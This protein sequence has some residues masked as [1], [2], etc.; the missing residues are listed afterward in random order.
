M[1]VKGELIVEGAKAFCSSSQANKSKATAVTVH[2]KSQT[3]KLGKNKY[4]AQDKPIATHL[5][6]KAENF[7]N[8]QAFVMCQDPKN[9]ST[10]YSPCA[11]MCKI[12]YKDFYENVEFNKSMKILIDKSTGTCP[13]YGVPGTIEFAKSGQTKGAS[14]IDVKEADPFAIANVSPQWESVLNSKEAS[15]VS[16]ISMLSPLAVKPNAE[17]KPEVYYFIKAAKNPLSFGLEMDTYLSLKATYKGDPQKIVWGLYKGEGIKDKVK[18]F[19]GIGANFN[20][21]LNSI[22]E[23]LEQGK[24]RI[25]AYVTKAN[26]SK[27]AFI[28][29]YVKDQIEAISAQGKTLV[30]NVPIPITLQYKIDSFSETTKILNQKMMGF[31]DTSPIAMWRIKQGETVLYNSLNGITSSFVNVIKGNPTV[32]TFKNIGEY[33]VEA[34]TD[35]NIEKPFSVSFK[36]LEQYGI[37]SVV[38]TSNI[39]LRYTDT[40]KVAVGKFN[41]EFAPTKNAQ[42]YL[43]KDGV[44]LKTFSQ[45]ATSKATSINRKIDQMLYNDAQGGSNYF[46]KYKLEAYATGVGAGKTP[47]FSGSDTFAFEV[48]QNQADKITLPLSI[49]KG[50]KVK[51]TATP[52]ISPMVGDEKLEIE[53]PD[54]V[55]NNNDGT[56]TFTEDGEFEIAVFMTGEYTIS[57]KVELKVKVTSPEVKNALWSYGTGYKRTETGYK[58]ETHGF[59]HI[60]GLENQTLP[61]KIWVKGE[62]E[63]IYSDASKKHLLEEKTVKLDDK[64]KGSFMI[65]TNDDY[66]KKIELAIPPTATNPNPTCRLVFTIELPTDASGGISLPDNMEI[67]HG[68]KVVGTKVIEILETNEELTL[69]NEKK[70]KSIV[71]STEDGKD[72]QRTISHYNRTHKIWVHT[73]NM[74]DDVL[75]IDVLKEVPRDAMVAVDNIVFTHESKQTYK[76]EKVGADGLLEV[77]FTVK[78]EWA[79]P[80]QNVDFYIAQVS[81]K[82]KDPNDDKKEI[83]TI[84]KTQITENSAVP[85]TIAHDKEMEKMG[86]KAQ[87]QD[88]SPFTVD[89]MVELRKKFMFY[90]MG[91]LKVSQLVSVEAISNDKSPVFVEIGEVNRQNAVCACKQNNFYWSARIS[92]EERKKVLEVCASLWG[93]AKKVE[94]ASE[95]M[96]IIHLETGKHTFKPSADNG[97]GYSGLIQFNDASAKALGTTREKLKAMTFIEQMDFVRDYFSKN[98]NALASMTDMYLLV[99]KPNA[100]GKGNEPSFVLFD[101]SISVPDGN[102]SGTS[103]QQ[104]LINVTQEPWVT[105]YGYA[106]NPPF[107]KGD[108]HTKRKKWVYTR[109]QY[110]QR[111]GFENGNTTVGEVTNELMLNH[112]DKGKPEKFAGS[113]K[114]A[115]NLDLKGRAPW[116]EIAVNEGKQY[117]GKKQS[118]IQDRVTQYHKEG[119]SYDVGTDAWCSSFACWCLENSTPKFVSPHSAGSRSFINHKTVESCEPFFGAIATFSD[120]NKEG[121][122]ESSGHVTFVFG[123]LID[124]SKYAVLGGNQGGMIKISSYDCSG[125]VFHSHYSSKRKRDIYKKFM[126]FF[127]PKGYLIKDID[128]L[129]ES[130]NYKAPDDANKKIGLGTVTT[131]SG[132][133]DD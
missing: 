39:L 54:G 5:D 111:W 24:Y 26:Y 38:A 60:V 30:K 93:E 46:G 15:S 72:V 107:M 123:K 40:V 71:F 50:A 69:T 13:G 28:I 114:N 124:S 9:T 76:E 99:L 66:K 1:A 115:P 25:E 95:L 112:Y 44:W 77:S 37:N 64:G 113:C 27:C 88:G 61:V 118:V 70:I 120:C 101:E 7:N 131:V 100:V 116:M 105:K 85:A 53:L 86:I 6:D 20:Q 127:K 68:R 110:E 121:V 18:T 8:G 19:V 117:G 129:I 43:Q 75:K 4:F 80:A 62:N 11:S 34:Y 29:E 47:N 122:V 57:D 65:T 97:A 102:G 96:S 83:Y 35:P 12:K 119:A 36:V 10:G 132:E 33:T 106:S 67:L 98:K 22:F 45:S 52:R 103:S 126:G 89:E 21:S 81:K 94:K 63:S 87:K 73:V 16:E 3:K 108:E 14:Q 82:V 133:K 49:P 32:V 48:I 58:E 84:L 109:Q 59:V 2:V 91:A 92:C 42:W 78:E 125:N 17:G 23:N 130:D 128:K 74:Q 79:K 56:L 51:Y 41:V 90:E 104:R 55:V 31:V